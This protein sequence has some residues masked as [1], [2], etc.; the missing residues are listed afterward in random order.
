MFSTL[1]LHDIQINIQIFCNLPTLELFLIENFDIKATQILF[2]I[3]KLD[4]L[5]VK[6]SDDF[7]C[8]ITDKVITSIE[9]LIK[10][11]KQKFKI[12]INIYGYLSFFFVNF[13]ILKKFIKNKIQ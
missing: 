12:E 7:I 2:I 11:E 1:L 9:I 5:N 6:F 13:S 4:S 8:Q 10:K 3:S